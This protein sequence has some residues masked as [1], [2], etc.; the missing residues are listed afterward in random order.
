MM[1]QPEYHTFPSGLRLGYLRKP[2]FPATTIGLYL[3]GG[4][5]QDPVGKEGTASLVADL[6]GRG[7]D[8]ISPF[9]CAKALESLGAHFSTFSSYQVTGFTLQVLS[10][11]LPTALELLHHFF[12]S[13]SFPEEELEKE[14]KVALAHQVQARQEPYGLLSDAVRILLYPGKRFQIPPEGDEHSI[15]RITREDL[16]RWYKNYFALSRCCMGI[17]SDKSMEEIVRLIEEWQDGFPRNAEGPLN[18]PPLP[19]LKEPRVFGV[20]M[21]V[22]QVFVQKVGWGIFRKDKYFNASR[23]WNYILGGGLFASRLF[24]NVRVQQGLVYSIFSQLIAGRE[25][26]GRFVLS[27]DTH[28][29]NFSSSM[30]SVESTIQQ[31]VSRGVTAREVRDAQAFFLG[32]L[33]RALQTSGQWARIILDGFFFDLPPNYWVQDLEEIRTIPRSYV[34]SALRNFFSSRILYTVVVTDLNTASS[35]FPSNTQL[36][37]T[38]DSLL[39]LIRRPEAQ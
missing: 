17:I 31:M 11:H 35:L 12:L 34:N 24:R 38:Y 14:K 15:P 27:W 9:E 30:E 23:I 26:P 8:H 10:H 28:I 5:C 6:L 4:G 3:E 37:L 36:F 18:Y 39:P 22:N 13:P 21:R 29:P 1:P 32:S 20:H 7:Y 2:S 19:D 25:Y 33:P 16:I